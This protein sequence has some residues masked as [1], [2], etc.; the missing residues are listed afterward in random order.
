M[1]IFTTHQCEGTHAGSVELARC[2]FR[3]AAAVAGSGYYAAY[4]KCRPTK[5]V[6]ILRDHPVAAQKVI[7]RWRTWGCTE[8]CKRRHEVIHLNMEIQK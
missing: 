7:D 4:S 3:K 5:Q 1:R 2:V 6:V 8:H